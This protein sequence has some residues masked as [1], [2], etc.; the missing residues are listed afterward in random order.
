MPEVNNDTLQEISSGR[1]ERLSRM[2]DSDVTDVVIRC[3]NML[4]PHAHQALQG[5]SAGDDGLTRPL[6]T[7]A[8]TTAEMTTDLVLPGWDGQSQPVPSVC[9]YEVAENVIGG[10]VARAILIANGFVSGYDTPWESLSSEAQLEE[11]RRRAGAPLYELDIGYPLYSEPKVTVS[12]KNVATGEIREV[13]Q[14]TIRH[15]MDVLGETL[16]KDR[17]R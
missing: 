3:L 8:V 11:L 15:A 14:D 7:Q 12:I 4:D 16:D 9:S 17:S 5:I 2:T 13:T 1:G 6:W 10:R